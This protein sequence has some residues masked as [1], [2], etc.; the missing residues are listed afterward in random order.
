MKHGEWQELNLVKAV[1]AVKMYNCPTKKAAET[2]G[3]PRT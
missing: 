2:H 3:I 1:R